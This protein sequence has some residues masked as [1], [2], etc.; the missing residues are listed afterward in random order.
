MDSTR[1]LFAGLVEENML[2]KVQLQRVFRLME[3]CHDSDCPHKHDLIVGSCCKTNDRLLK[4]R[5]L[6]LLHRYQ[7]LVK[8]IQA[9]SNE[10]ESSFNGVENVVSRL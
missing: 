3:E 8:T 2:L 4:R 10:L 7:T 5:E 6:A 1:E 9:E